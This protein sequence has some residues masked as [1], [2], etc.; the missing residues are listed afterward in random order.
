HV[1]HRLHRP[2]VVGEH[3][4]DGQ[5]AVVGLGVALVSPGRE[6]DRP[7]RPREHR[8]AREIPRELLGRLDAEAAGRRVEEAPATLLLDGVDRAALFLAHLPAGR[9]LADLALGEVL[10]RDAVLGPG[11]T[12][13]EPRQGERGEDRGGDERPAGRG[14][15]AAPR[16]GGRGDRAYRPRRPH[17]CTSGSP[18]PTTWAPVR[19]S[20]TTSQERA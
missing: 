16:D 10:D 13:G 3:A 18:A 8:I 12:G 20:F 1:L 19:H 15:G 2:H 14:A 9:E 17:W 11:R 5:R 4:V 7:P 6:L